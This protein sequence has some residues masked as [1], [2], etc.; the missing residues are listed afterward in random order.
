MEL[1][2]MSI[3]PGFGDAILDGRK[4]A[5]LRRLVNGPI[6]PGDTIVLYLSSPRKAIE[7]FF[8]AGRVY[9][10]R[11][12]EL[13]SIARGLGDLGLREGDWGYIDEDREGMMILVNEPRRCPRPITLEQLINLIRGFKPP[14][15][16]VRL[17]PNSDLY[18][19]IFDRCLKPY[20]REMWG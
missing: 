13:M 12:S 4:R 1:V 16:Y 17:R 3:K 6:M 18:W 2:L 20:L 10:G 11:R 8:R 19:V 5:E 9:I 14:L 15:S 7:G